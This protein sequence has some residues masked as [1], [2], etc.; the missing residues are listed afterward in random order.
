MKIITRSL[1]LAPEMLKDKNIR[2]VVSISDPTIFDSNGRVVSLEDNIPANLFNIKDRKVLRL[3]FNDLEEQ[4]KKCP[5]HKLHKFP[6]ISHIEDIVQLASRHDERFDVLTH[7]HGGISRSG[8]ASIII[9]CV[10]FND[11][12]KA[13]ENV[14][15]NNPFVFPNSL[16]IKLA[17][18][19]LGFSGSLLKLI[20]DFKKMAVND[21]LLDER[22]KSIIHKGFIRWPFL[23]KLLKK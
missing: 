18:D 8:A 4:D 20:N 9:G 3:L 23:F 21:M 11:I 19:F 6:D 16:M 10:L 1:D 14:I 22:F 13:L 7:C 2:T 5:A 17:D 15:L 12:D